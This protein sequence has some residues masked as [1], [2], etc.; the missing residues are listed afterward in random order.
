[1]TGPAGTGR[2]VRLALRRD[3]TTLAVWLLAIGGLAA[4]FTAMSVSSLPTQADV[5]QETALF[6]GAPAMRLLGLPSGATVG[7]YVLLRGQLTLAVLAA[8]M[9]VF[10]VV[11]HT[12]QDEE[13]GR[14]ELV[15]SGVAGRHARLAAALAVAVLAN[16]GA[17]VV[18]AVGTGA[19]GL[20]VAGAVAAGASVGVVG[21]VLGGVAAVAAQLTTTARGANALAG[22]A[23]AVAWLLSGLGNVLG[24]VDPDGV[25]VRSAWPAWLSPVGWGQQ[26]RPFD[27]LTWWPLGLGALAFVALA[28]HAA[29]LQARRDF[30][31]GVLPERRG[32]GDAPWAST[33][34]AGLVRR[35]HRS[36]DLGWFLA[37]GAFGL[38][39]GSMTDAMTRLDGAALDWYTATAGTDRI[40]PAFQTA[41]L[42]LAAPAVGLYVVQLL[43]RLR[44]DEVGG[45]TELLHTTPVAPVR[46]LAAHAVRA[47]VVAA[48]LLVTFSLALAVAAAGVDGTAGAGALLRAGLAQLPAVLVLGGLVTM[49]VGLTPRLAPVLGWALVAASVLLGPTFGSAVGAPRWATDLSPFTHA[50][51]APAVAVPPAAVAVLATIGLVA[52]CAGLVAVRRRDQRLPV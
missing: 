3:R 22:A 18:V 28:G 13:N 20:P 37:L 32:R 39:L 50:S 42:Q 15:S 1:M 40:V 30:G 45:R 38:V 16:A 31:L 34:V 19:Q 33:R 14:A 21:L 10:A 26:V 46:W 6:A 29:R 51:Q 4:A 23:L 36:S 49:A 41:M 8:L 44:A 9:S 11:R 17:A 47:T 35:L 27:D 2:L 7:G 25:T 43:L 12:R 5:V 24:D 48:L 52:G